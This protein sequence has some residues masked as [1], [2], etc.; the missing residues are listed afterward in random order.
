MNAVCVRSIAGERPP[1]GVSG[2]DGAAKIWDVGG[3]GESGP[4]T[5]ES[6][7]ND[8]AWATACDRG[9]NIDPVLRLEKRLDFNMRRRETGGG[10]LDAGPQH[11][12]ESLAEETRTTA[13]PELTGSVLRKIQFLRDC[14]W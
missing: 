13:A 12:G 1:A 10:P 9:D 4:V 6:N 3:G 11:Y 2:S 14:D 7:G 8:R 5:R